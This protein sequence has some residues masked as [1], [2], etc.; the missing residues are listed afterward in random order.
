MASALDRFQE[1]KAF[2]DTKSSVKGLVVAGV[3]TV[4][5]IFHHPPGRAGSIFC[6]ALRRG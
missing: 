6:R 2:D 4:P 3:S 1:L 5:A